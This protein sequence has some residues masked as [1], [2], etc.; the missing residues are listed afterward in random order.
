[1]LELFEN[2]MNLS[3]KESINVSNLNNGIYFIKINKNN[4]VENQNCDLKVTYKLRHIA[5]EDLISRSNTVANKKCC[6]KLGSIFYIF[7]KYRKTIL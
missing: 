7:E 4:I 2:K 6:P 5:K 1:M 3:R